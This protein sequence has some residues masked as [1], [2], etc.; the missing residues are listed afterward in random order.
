MTRPA[1][2]LRAVTGALVCLFAPAATTADDGGRIVVQIPADMGLEALPAR[3][4]AQLETVTRSGVFHR[5]GFSDRR[6]DSGITFHHQIVDDAG[7]HYKLVHYDHGNG[8]AAADVDGDGRLDLYFTSQLGANELWRNLGG[9]RFE[10]VT[11][12]AGVALEERVSVSASFADYD[13]DGD[14]DLYVT[15]VRMGNALFANDGTGRFRDVTE[16]AGLA[17]RGHSSSG[18]FFDYDNDGQLDLLLT[19]VGVYTTD[20]RG[21]GG[22]FVGIDNAFTGQLIPGRSERSIL[23]RGSD[24]GRFEDVSER[25]LLIDRSWSG[26]ATAVDWNGDRFSDLYV[27]NMQGPDHYYQN[28]GG[29]FFVDKT[30][31]LF[32]KTPPGTM[33]VKVFDWNGDRLLDL[34]LTDMHSDMSEEIGPEREKEKA[35]AP[36]SVPREA[37]ERSILGNALWQNTGDGFREVSDSAGVENYWPWGVS[38]DDLNADGWDD[39]FI[40]SSMN[41]PF[42]YGVSSLLLNDGGKRFLDSEFVLGVEPRQ[43]G[44]TKLW[45][46]VDCPTGDGDGAP[47]PVEPADPGVRGAEPCRGRDGPIAVTAARGTRSSVIFDLD[48]DGDLDLVTLEFFDRPR[49]LV[50]DLSERKP[51]RFLKVKLTGTVSNRDGLGARVTVTA[52]G[53]SRLK[54]HDG[55]SGY[56]SQSALPLYFGLGDAEAVERVEVAWPAGAVQVVEKPAING[57]V[58]VVEE[59]KRRATGPRVETRG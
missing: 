47:E 42:R 3:R 39:V 54:V 49:V 13:N 23:Y 4:A 26:D 24:D 45:F 27:L 22:Y 15:T 16:E 12:R 33:G 48:G 19:N 2:S 34:L 57:L 7:R 5:F 41:Y 40:A 46:E 38:V 10:D 28:V 17:Y 36:G 53:R 59:E 6:Q 58:E 35:R 9:G 21:R 50:S 55:K 32:P 44:M 37:L 1:N 25:A 52:G 11:E 14:Q 29:K 30:A 20:E 31:D 8:L 56:L 43:G 51:I 18:V